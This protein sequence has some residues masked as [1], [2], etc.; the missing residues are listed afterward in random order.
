MEVD[1]REV[2]RDVLSGIKNDLPGHLHK[3]RGHRFS[4]YF[5]KNFIFSHDLF[6]KIR[7]VDQIDLMIEIIDEYVLRN[8]E[9]RIKILEQKQFDR[10]FI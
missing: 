10:E 9:E 6:K 7:N 3:S 4:F 5:C 8:P 2:F 1:L